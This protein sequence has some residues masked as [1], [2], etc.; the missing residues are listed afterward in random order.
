MLHGVLFSAATSLFEDNDSELEVF[1]AVNDN[2]MVFWVRYHS[3][4]WGIFCPAK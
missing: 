1:A 2:I 3:N 4:P